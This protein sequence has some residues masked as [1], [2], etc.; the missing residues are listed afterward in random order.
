M[1][2]VGSASAAAVGL[3]EYTTRTDNI[4]DAGIVDLGFHYPGQGRY[5]LL[6]TIN[7]GHGTV[8]PMTG[9]YHEFV[10]VA[11]TAIPDPG[12]RVKQWIGTLREVFSDLL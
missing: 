12:Y 11:L 8:T 6:V 3:D 9:S 4:S 5:Q 1:V 2:D 10:E 7:G